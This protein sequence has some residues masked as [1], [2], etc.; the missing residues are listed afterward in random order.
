M[1]RSGRWKLVYFAEGNAPMLF[2]LQS[3]PQELTDLASDS[4]YSETLEDM[5][6]QLRG[7]LDP[8]AVNRQAFADQAEMIEKLG[9]MDGIRAMASFNYTP[10]D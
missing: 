1:L 3:D 5:I 4:A 9:G 7:I 10:L 2:D 6:G 8:E